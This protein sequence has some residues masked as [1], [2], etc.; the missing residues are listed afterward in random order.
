MSGLN[1]I[2]KL[3][4]IEEKYFDVSVTGNVAD[5]GAIASLSQLVQ[6]LDINQRVGDSI[7]LQHIRVFGTWVV[8]ASATG[9]ACRIIIFRDL[10]QNGTP[11][12]VSDVLAASSGVQGVNAPVKAINVDRFAILFDNVTCVSTNGDQQLA[13]SFDVAH[14]GHI[15][16]LGT[17]AAAASEGRGTLYLL[18]ISDEASNTPTVSWYSRIKYT[19]D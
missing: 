13:F 6:G 7:R 14:N 2:R 10:A 9:S 18:N 5:T 8:N 4:N 19:D 3:I 12:S 16:Y 17:T 15:R 1:E 11:P